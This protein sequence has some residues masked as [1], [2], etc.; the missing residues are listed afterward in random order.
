MT[1]KVSSG[2]LNLCSLTH[3]LTSMALVERRVASLEGTKA[4]EATKNLAQYSRPEC[5]RQACWTTES[6]LLETSERV[7]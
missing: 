1:Y 3:S 4:T 6:K 7:K 5:D 2:T